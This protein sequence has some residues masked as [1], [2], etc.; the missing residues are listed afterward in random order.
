MKA[1]SEIWSAMVADWKMA[2]TISLPIFVVALCFGI[3]RRYDQIWLY[4]I[5][6]ALGSW[7]IGGTAAGLVR[8]LRAH[9]FK[10]RGAQYAQPSS[11]PNRR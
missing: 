11:G 6:M 7:S 4:A 9:R 3:W 2:L 5:A 8:R 1:L 10:N